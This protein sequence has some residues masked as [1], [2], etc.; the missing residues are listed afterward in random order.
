MSDRCW[1]MLDRCWINTYSI[2]VGDVDVGSIVV[3]DVG[4]G[5]IDVGD[6]DG[7]SI[8]GDICIYII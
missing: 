5:S 8:V 7:R 2:V 4:V 3:G 6:G 1:M